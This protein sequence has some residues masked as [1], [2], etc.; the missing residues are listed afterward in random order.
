MIHEMHDM[1]GRVRSRLRRVRVW[2]GLAVCWLVWAAVGWGAWALAVQYEWPWAWAAVALAAVVSAFVCWQILATAPRDPHWVAARIES[3]FPELGA[4]L[5]AALE[6]APLPR[7]RRLGY[8]QYSVVKNAVTHGRRT[9]WNGAVPTRQLWLAQLANLAAFVLLVGACLLLMGRGDADARVTVNPPGRIT[10]SAE[11]YDVE[12]QPG[13]TEI[14]RGT[15]LLV[16]ARFGDGVPAEASLV[17]ENAADEL[18]ETPDDAA[19]ADSPA[20][21]DN[22]MQ[23]RAM[24]RSLDDPKFVGRVPSVPHDLTYSVE[25]GDWQSRKYRVTVF[26]YPVL[27]R[28]DVRLNYPEFT[29]LEPKLIE[30]VRHVTAVEGTELTILCRLNKEVD[31]ARLI[32]RDGEELVL[33]RDD[34]EAPVYTATLKL[35]KSRRFKLHLKDSAGRENKLPPEFVVNVKP[36]RPPNLKIAR[37]ARDV[38]VSPLEE[39]SLNA[40]LSDDFGLLRYGV[41]YSLGGEELYDVVLSDN[42]DE[43]DTA[44]KKRDKLAHLI[45]FESLEAEPDDLVSYYLWVEDAV[46]G[47]QVRLTMSDMYFA[48]VRHFEDIFRQG[49]Q[50]TEQQQREQ[51]QQQQEG[52]QGAGQRAEQLAELQKEIVNATWKLIRRETLA[53]PTREFADDARLV[54][55]SQ[56]EALGQL[57][58]LAGELT[59]EESLLYVEEA[60]EKM[61]TV[62]TRLAAAADGPAVP[63]LRPALSDEQAA[64][65]ALLK[66]RAREFNVVQGGQQQQG[67]SSGSASGPGSRAQRQLNQLELSS[68]ENRYETQSRAQSSREEQAAQNRDEARQVL[69]RLRELARRQQDLNERLRETQSQLEAAQTEEERNEIERELKRLREQQQEILRDTDQLRSDLEN[70]ENQEQ[71]QEPLEQLDETRSRVQQASEALEEGQL[72]QAVTEGTRAG[73]QLSELRDDFRRRTADR[74]SDEM[75]DLRE[76]VRQLD[77]RQ[78]QLSDGLAEQ[79]DPENRSLRG[80]GDREEIGQ[81]LTDQRRQYDELIEQMQETVREAEEPE[82]LLARQLYDTVQ[83]ATDHN[84]DEALDITQQLLEIGVTREAGEAMRAADEGIRQLREGV[85][86]AA[87]SVL[88]SETEALRRAEREI[89]DLAEELDREIDNAQGQQDDTDQPP[90]DGQP[91]PG[92]PGRNSQQQ[93]DQQQR[94]GQNGQGRNQQNR[95][96]QGQN[97]PGQSQQ[98]EN[99]EGQNGQQGA[100]PG[101]QQN[102]GQNNG[103]GRQANDDENNEQRQTPDGDQQQQPAGGGRG[104][105]LARDDQAGGPRRNGGGG[106]GGELPRDL[107]DFLEQFTD[108]GGPITGDDFRPWGDRLRNVEDLLD[109]PE[110]SAEAA[111]IRDRAEAARAEYKR[112]AKEPD[113]NKL[114]DLVAEPLRELQHRINQEI[115]RRESPDALVPIDR[116]PVPAEYTEQVRLYFERLGS[117]E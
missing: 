83:Q 105:R 5:L 62:V 117:G 34:G 99:Q 76:S 6:Q 13:D 56:E 96:Q 21:D 10:P 80:S 29:S 93:Q 72:S 23:N 49:E 30:D 19:D 115:R 116:D 2:S 39:L 11:S 52:Q 31:S 27:E 43:A 38:R 74:F 100:Q 37:P 41:S 24:V 54:G 26:D 111:R 101:Q 61:Q 94:D 71:L 22:R 64:Y 51:Q 79:N 55:E 12:I 82:P 90:G 69:D 40:E 14:E 75:R 73:R 48:E 77:E 33:S 97:R 78:Q 88:G 84:I 70:S 98:G 102:G 8:L 45:D 44:K 32:D 9:S 109:D 3:K 60:R 18:A 16:V 59:D 91:R 20:G 106:P 7:N 81:G 17:L 114:T 86:S 1:L 63:E 46:A 36:N 113:W 95:D 25:V 92:Q 89:E 57:G 87:Q 42:G 15:T 103:G 35:E 47:G 108:P 68:E 28:A 65:Q 85:E 107:E 67:P 53:E 66:L 50:P 112:H 58:E 4:A 104:G 110:L